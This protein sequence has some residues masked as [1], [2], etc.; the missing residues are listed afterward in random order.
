ML[1][2][3]TYDNIKETDKN[4]KQKIPLCLK[5]RLSEYADKCLGKG[6]GGD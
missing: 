6:Q 3:V 5:H 2:L 4:V 1:S